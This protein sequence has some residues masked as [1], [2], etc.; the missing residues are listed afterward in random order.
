MTLTQAFAITITALLLVA[1]AAQSQA[2]NSF[3][4]FL[5][6]HAETNKQ[7]PD[8]SDPPLH[9][10]G[11]I[12]ANNLQQAMASAQINAVYSSDYQRTQATAAPTA[13]SLGLT[14][15]SYDPRQLA[16]FAQVLLSL[17]QNALVVGHSNTTPALARLLTTEAVAPIGEDQFNQLYK[18]TVSGASIQLEQLQQQQ[19]HCQDLVSPSL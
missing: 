3:E 16:Q 19:L 9:R 4:L 7:S 6:R 14:I 15:Q 2:N 13:N 12:R 17:R 10:C 8:D 18:V 1:T 5:V 11:V